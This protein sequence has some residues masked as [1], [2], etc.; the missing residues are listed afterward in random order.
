MRRSPLF[1]MSLAV[2]AGLSS[3]Q[4][5]GSNPNASTDN[6]DHHTSHQ[7]NCMEYWQCIGS[8]GTPYTY[9]NLNKV[10]C[11]V[12]SGAK[13]VG[14]LPRQSKSA[15]C[16][17]K[18]SDTGRDG[19]ADPGEWSWQAAILEKSK[20]IYVCG[21]SLLDEFWIMTA[22]H[23][24]DD[25]VPKPGELKIRLGEY[26]V[27]STTETMGH[28]EFDVARI[29]LHPDFNNAT[30]LHDIALVKLAR[31]ARKRPNINT[32]CMPDKTIPEKELIVST[33]CY[34]TGWGKRNENSPHS[35]ILKEINVPM[36]RSSDCE[37]ALKTLF[38]PS[39]KLPSTTLCAG[40][41]G[42]DA[43]DGDGGGPLV[44]EKHGH[45]YQVGIVSFGVG[46]GRANAPGVYTK[47]DSY[48][49]W[50]HNI[51]LHST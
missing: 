5:S 51:V 11:F 20:E 28:E 48:K 33:K 17:E 4:G 7:C 18:G 39:F 24:V 26:D 10:C 31:A 25:Y 2:L 29:V 50:I 9:C 34:V 15:K 44:C 30:L 3:A 47:V 21:A 42:R 16:G 41:E 23:C 45:W 8:G 37:T 38:G 22:A 6:H 12:K 40:A 27:S 43:C 19:V 46:C 35:V 36:W 14:I 13:A 1:V 49:N 32:I